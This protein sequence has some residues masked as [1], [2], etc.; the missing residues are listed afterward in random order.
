LHKLFSLSIIKTLKEIGKDPHYI[1]FGVVQ[2]SRPNRDYIT[3]WTDC[4]L[5]LACK[6]I[7]RHEVHT[8]IKIIYALAAKIMSF[9]RFSL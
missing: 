1:R 2:S 9:M 6:N 5:S 7:T 8:L 4:N 3:P